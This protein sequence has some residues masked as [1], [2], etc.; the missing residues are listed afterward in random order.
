MT[1][2][3]GADEIASTA[4]TGPGPGEIASIDRLWSA[5]TKTVVDPLN[6]FSYIALA[7]ASRRLCSM[8]R[9]SDTIA[10]G[11]SPAGANFRH[12]ERSSKG[13]EVGVSEN[14]QR[15]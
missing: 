10:P 12:P 13:G 4:G 9:S 7:F 14:G 2:W 15:K 8:H 3:R 6:H 11:G 5:K 1:G